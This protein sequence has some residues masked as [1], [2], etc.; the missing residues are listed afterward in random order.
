MDKKIEN[1]K[2]TIDE[3]KKMKP[4]CTINELIKKLE[5]AK[6][7][8]LTFNENE[9]LFTEE[10]FT[11]TNYYS[12]SIYRKHLPSIEEKKYSFSDCMILYDFNMFLRS[13]LNRITGQIE[14]MLKSSFLKSLCENYSGDLQ[15]GECYLDCEIYASFD[16]FIDEKSVINNRVQDRIKTL[17]IS[18][19]IE[20]KNGKIPFW[21]IVPELTFGEM[22]GFI[23]S[24]REDIKVQWIKDSFLSLNRINKNIYSDEII[25]KMFGWFS[26]TW[27]IRNVCAHYGRLYGN[28]FNIGSP[29]IF[30]ED[31]R[32]IKKYGKKKTHNRDLFAYMMAMKNILTFHSLT[33]QSEWNGFLEG[34]KIWIEENPEIILLKKI[35]FTENWKDV[36]M[37][38]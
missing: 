14:L 31:F 37:I 5:C 32:K 7:N 12:F 38:K 17:P 33:V 18:H 8:P 23:S 27:Y 15:K 24:V 36:L 9:R 29:S 1:F 20:Y 21:V 25:K 19:H 30:S 13:E 16:K 3:D 26:S 2:A 35:G 22:T 28:N 4:F 6:V 10:F 34:I 11:Y